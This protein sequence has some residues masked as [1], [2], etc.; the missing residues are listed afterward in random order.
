MD[1]AHIV[2][3]GLIAALLS[4]VL[5][6]QKPEL[7]MIIALV[8]GIIIFIFTVDKL[9]PVLDILKNISEKAHVDKL[10]LGITLKIVGIAYITEFAAQILKDAEEN[11]IASRVEFG[12]K[13]LI[14]LQALPILTA[15][16]DTVLNIMR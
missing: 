3:L 8:T 12:G 16:V 7:S 13:V 2:M 11:S 4:I 1:I 6:E 5:K 10:Y 15:L 9:L 14:L